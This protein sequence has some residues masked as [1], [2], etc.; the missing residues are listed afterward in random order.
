MVNKKSYLICA[1]HYDRRSS[2]IKA[3]YLLCGEL[4]DLGY[5]AY[6]TGDSRD[7]GYNTKS[8]FSLNKDQL[9]DIQ[10]NGVVIY[11]DN[12][13]NGNPLRFTNVVR[14]FL[15]ITCITPKHELVFSMSPSHNFFVRA[16]Y[17]LMILRVES[18][19]KLP[20]VENRTK[21]CFRVGKG[22]AIPRLSVTDGCIEITADYPSNRRELAKLLQE[23]EVMYTYD[24]F[25]FLIT[26]ALLCGCPVVILGHPITAKEN[27][28][29]NI[30]FKYGAGFIDDPDLDI[31]KLKEEIPLQIELWNQL[32]NNS[33][34]ELLEFIT[35]TQNMNNEYVEDLGSPEPH[36]WIALGFWSDFF[37]LFKER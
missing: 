11:P 24:N 30:L 32:M 37:S 7:C 15:G 1:P 26:E 8:I 3:L 4:N 36:P 17:N 34:K 13:I 16:P 14:W 10:L 23:C 5:T 2:G 28:K 35:L 22:S 18:Y 9:K 31:K 12:I 19:F 21:K 27:L 33:K 29:N 6:I 25:T 20:E